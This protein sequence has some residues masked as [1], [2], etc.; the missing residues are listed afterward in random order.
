[1][2][3]SRQEIFS[4]WALRPCSTQRPSAGS[5]RSGASIG[6]PLPGQG[7]MQ[8]QRAQVVPEV[9]RS[10]RFPKRLNPTQKLIRTDGDPHQHPAADTV[11]FAHSHTD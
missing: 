6:M 7:R 10:K 5:Y 3:A 1:M 8:A 11:A 4:S 2:I 9:P